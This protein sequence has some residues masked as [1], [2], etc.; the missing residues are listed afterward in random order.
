M[1]EAGPVVRSKSKPPNGFTV[2][3]G[4]ISGVLSPA[5]ARVPSVQRPH[6]PVAYHFGSDGRARN[7]VALGVAVHDR[8]VHPAQGRDGPSIYK[9][10]VGH[11]VEPADGTAHGPN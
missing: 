11:D 8:F 2:F 1:N 3:S 6:Q 9:K 4:C 5:V 10:N 7:R